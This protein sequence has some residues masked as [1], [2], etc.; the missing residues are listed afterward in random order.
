MRRRLPST[1]ALAA[2][3]AAARHGSYTRAAEELAVTQSAV[4]RQIGTLEAQLGVALFRRGRRGV[5]LTDAG[6]SYAHS[7]AQRLHELEQDALALA[8]TRGHGAVLELAVVPTFGTRWLI[9]RLP[10]FA[11]AHPGITLHLHSRIRPFLFDDD[12]GLDAALHAGHA[13]W[14]GTERVPLLA[15]T[16]VA[17]AG[18]A[19]ART[20]KA[21]RRSPLPARLHGATL[22]QMATRPLAWRQWFGAQGAVH[23]GDLAGPRFELYGMVAEAAVHGLGVALV[24]RLLVEQELQAGSLVRL[25]GFEMPSGNTYS[26]IVPEARAERP[27]VVALR[28]W[29]LHEAAAAAVPG[30]SL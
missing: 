25:D 24:P 2:F 4:C 3:D 17:V 11:A 26:L 13:P 8:A 21:T 1:A 18:P 19:L 7:V 15:E 16:L 28:Q 10:R 6:V 20:L 9:P 5:L 23:A 30:G 12:A 22:L 14:P 29:L 27:A